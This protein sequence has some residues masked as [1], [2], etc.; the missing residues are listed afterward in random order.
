MLATRL[1]EAG[2]IPVREGRSVAIFAHTSGE[3]VRLADQVRPLEPPGN[4][5]TVERA[6]DV[7]YPEWQVRVKVRARDQVGE[8][9][10]RL[11]VAGFPSTPR[12][13]SVLIGARTQDEAQE[14]ADRIEGLALP[15]MGVEVERTSRLW[16][17]LGAMREGDGPYGSG[18]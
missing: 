2:F 14:V 5:V 16:R 12:W 18:F 4:K 13:R 9:R 1:R 8:I 11:R 6:I 7:S 3:A 17:V 10:R 15:G